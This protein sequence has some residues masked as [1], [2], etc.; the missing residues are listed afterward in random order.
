MGGDVFCY[1]DLARYLGADQ[2][3]YGLQ[4]RAW[5][6]E[7]EP[8]KTVEEMAAT[9][10]QAI[11]ELRPHGPYMLAGWSFGGLVALE[12]ARQLIAAGESVGLLG[13]MDTNLKVRAETPPWLGGLNGDFDV[14]PQM[15]WPKIILRFARAGRTIPE[16]ELR[17]FETVEDQVAHAVERGVLPPGLSVEGAMC[18]VRASENNSRARNTYVPRPYAGRVTLFRALQGHVLRCPDPTLGWKEIALGGL[19]IV[20]VPGEHDVMIEKPHVGELARKMR[21]CVDRACLSD[22]KS[23]VAGLS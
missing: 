15:D 22:L 17:R 16:E 5:G 20:E 1:L 4:A 12:M 11:R 19:E 2:P 14:E 7:G 6:G 8:E 13:I 9:N 10:V 3:V 23:I 21:E 18:Y